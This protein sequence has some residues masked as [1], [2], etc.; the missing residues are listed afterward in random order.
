MRNDST[1][2]GSF[3]CTAECYF[4]GNYCQLE[5]QLVEFVPEM[6]LAN[7]RTYTFVFLGLFVGMAFMWLSFLIIC[8]FMLLKKQK[9][10]NRLRKQKLDSGSTLRDIQPKSSGYDTI[11]DS[12]VAFKSVHNHEKESLIQDNRQTIP[13]LSE[14][15]TQNLHL[16]DL[17]MCVT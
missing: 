8:I 14:K 15:P 10:V 7:W 4:N 11:D 2:L 17:F 13:N 6:G 9:T 3:R 1:L 16:K 12:G 5:G